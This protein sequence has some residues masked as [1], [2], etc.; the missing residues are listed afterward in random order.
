MEK[1][2]YVLWRKPDASPESLRDA[3]RGDV[4]GAL[5]D[6]GASRIAV[7]V[8]DEDT[9]HALRARIVR[10]DPPPDA[11]LSFWLETHDDRAP[12]EAAF[13]LVTARA[14]G[15][16]VAESVPLVNTAHAAAPGERTPG[17]NMVALIRQ[18]DWIDHA[19]WLAR[20]L[21]D[22]R[23]VAL[24]TQST[25]GYVRNVVVRALTPD[26]PLF[27]GVVEELFP[28]DAVTDPMRWYAA[29]GSKD[30][31]AANLGR[32]MESCKAFL[33]LDR[34]ETHPMSEYRLPE[35]GE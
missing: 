14:A 26:A 18:P 20:W 5:R 21:E 13:A 9:D 2:V 23:V 1:L 30:R 32:M 29:D 6:A 15:Y 17:V 7:N 34:V 25:F 8:V 27:A 12:C 22:H 3:L 19:A 31:L 33:D 11:L 35:P 16:L 24:E 28:A 4:A 10:L